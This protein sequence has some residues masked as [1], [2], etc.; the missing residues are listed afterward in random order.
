MRL[1]IFGLVSA[2]ETCC[3]R[4]TKKGSNARRNIN[5]L[6]NIVYVAG[7]RT[8]YLNGF[9]RR[10]PPCLNV[11]RWLEA[12]V[13]YFTA[14]VQTSTREHPVRSDDWK[15]RRWIYIGLVTRKTGQ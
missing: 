10:L 14:F 5:S 1:D 7:I 11:A 15:F 3:S 2:A 12:P 13:D 6:E 9:S 8:V 4:V